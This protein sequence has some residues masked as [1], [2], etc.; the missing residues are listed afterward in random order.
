MLA[1]IITGPKGIVNIAFRY[2]HVF[3]LMSIVPE[4]LNICVAILILRKQGN[5][6]GPGIVRFFSGFMI[7][8]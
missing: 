8:L 3:V 7:D 2:I 5:I 4:N 6:I 1:T